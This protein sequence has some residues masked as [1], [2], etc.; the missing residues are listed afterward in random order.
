MLYGNRNTYFRFHNIY[1][2]DAR[3]LVF[4][5]MGTEFMV[6]CAGSVHADICISESVVG[7]AVTLQNETFFTLNCFNSLQH[8]KNET[9]EKNRH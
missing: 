3:L 2:R 5:D 7:S 9:A 8:R 4:G 1:G 6:W